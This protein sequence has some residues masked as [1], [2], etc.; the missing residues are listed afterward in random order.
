MLV[1]K[2]PTA[3]S[4]PELPALSINEFVQIGRKVFPLGLNLTETKVMILKVLGKELL[5][6]D[7]AFPLMV[8]ASASKLNE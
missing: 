4:A 2:L 3:S 8:V 1:E 5:T 6:D 7:I